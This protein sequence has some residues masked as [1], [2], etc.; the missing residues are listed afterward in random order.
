MDE[1][2]G[3]SKAIHVL[4]VEDNPGDA[5]FVSLLL[6]ENSDV[7]FLVT[8]VS[9]LAQAV[10]LSAT[11]GFDV[12][13]TDLGLPDSSGAET[14]DAILTAWP[15]TPVVVLTGLA[16]R[17][18]GTMAV[19][20]GCQDFLIKGF[21][22][23][24]LLQ[25]TLR[26]AIERAAAAR[27]LRESEER[28]RTLVDLSPDAI[29]L[30]GAHA[31]LFANERAMV[32]F[33]ASCREELIGL[34]PAALFVPS[35]PQRRLPALTAERALGGIV[36]PQRVECRLSRLDGS[37][38]DGE[39]SLASIDHQERP[40][41]EVII[42]DITERKLAERHHHLASI[43]FETT[44]EA[45][46]VTDGSN[47]IIAVNPAFER[48]TGYDLLDVVGRNPR[49]LASGRHDRKFYEAMWL[50]LG[51]TGHWHGE[52]WNRRKNGEIYVQRLTLSLIRDVDGHV[53]NHVG[54]FSDITD[55]KQEAERIRYR[56]SYDALTGLPNRSLLHDRLQ[57]SLAKMVRE[58]GLLGVLF[59]DL[60]GF[61]PV[62]DR[63]GHLAGDH[64]L[65]ALSERLQGC[66]RESDTVARLGGDE[67][68][69]ILPDMASPADAQLVAAKIL[70][71]LSIPF[72]LQSD[73]SSVQ[74]GASIGIALYPTHGH[75]AEE[76]VCAADKA[77][78][79][80]KQAGRGRFLFAGEAADNQPR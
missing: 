29:L 53:V 11:G 56:A 17:M 74:I 8:E 39:M 77:M 40:A 9:T 54:V 47:H 78:Y 4:V 58:R 35:D 15:R 24:A 23:A 66:V 18:A 34:D 19:Q 30:C 10:E 65:V 21:A 73:E 2:G 68:I 28:F 67:F 33:R 42:R 45:M 32:M 63:Y 61:K 1:A 41:A 16:D 80:A 38:F 72:A 57:Q 7:P 22:D 62:N 6:A 69:I 79:E 60:D 31:I 50:V 12:V 5:R 48:V 25:R 43:V 71:A 75:T 20:R 44:D 51:R 13:L 55:E 70:S 76:L 52:V 46:M 36:E 59:L 49:I 3:G 27:A 64:L 14:V 37:A 26:Y